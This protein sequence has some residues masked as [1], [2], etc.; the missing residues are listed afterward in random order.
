MTIGFVNY[1]GHAQNKL[2]AKLSAD[3]TQVARNE[4]IVLTLTFN[5]RCDDVNR[6]EMKDFN[7]LSE[8]GNKKTI[9][10]RESDGETTTITITQ[11]LTLAVTPRKAGIFKIDPFIFVKG[12]REIKTNALVIQVDDR[13]ISWQDSAN[14]AEK[15]TGFSIGSEATQNVQTKSAI[16]YTK[17]DKTL[18]PKEEPVGNGTA[19]FEIQPSK[20]QYKVK[21]GDQFYVEYTVYREAP[22]TDFTNNIEMVGYEDL[23]NF[24]LIDGPARHLQV[25]SNSTT[26]VQS[27]TADLILEAPYKLGKYILPPMTVKCGNHVITSATIEVIVE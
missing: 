15:F 16:D 26:K 10:E 11:T 25:K 3:R 9:E 4:P 8:P 7:I 27:G 5:E 20:A 19:S 13:K 17:T 22:K 24:T 14:I 2:Q 12:N 18:V 6:P 23:E 1:A 21:A